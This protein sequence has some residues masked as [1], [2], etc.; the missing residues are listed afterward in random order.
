LGRG[1][2][3]PPSQVPAYE[4]DRA[5]DRECDSEREHEALPRRLLERLA[6]EVSEQRGVESPG[7]RRDRVKD[8]EPPPWIPERSGAHSDDRAATRNETGDQDQLPAALAH[9]ALRPVDP[10]SSLLAA[11]EAVVDPGSEA[12][13]N[14]VSGV[15][16]EEGS[17]GRGRDHQHDVEIAGRRDHACRDDRRLA[18]HHRHECVEVRQQKEDQVRPAR[19]VRNQIGELAE[20]WG[21]A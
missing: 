11:E 1:R 14:V 18:R 19:G 10:L 13:A 15:V 9:L 8:D 2:A 21:L 12:V 4:L 7:E 5:C 17:G 6:A 20:D 16:S 3:P